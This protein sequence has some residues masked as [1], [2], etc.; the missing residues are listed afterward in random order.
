MTTLGAIAVVALC[1]MAAAFLRDPARH[2]GGCGGCGLVCD[3]EAAG[4]ACGRRAPDDTTHG[5]RPREDS[6][7]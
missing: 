3:R 7:G 6:H 1:F 2:R 5:A 4:G